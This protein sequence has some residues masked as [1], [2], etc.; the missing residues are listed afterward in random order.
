MAKPQQKNQRNVSEPL[1][2]PGALPPRVAAIRRKI[3]E[4]CAGRDIEALRIPV[5]WNEVRPLFERG[6]RRAPGADPIAILKELAADAEGLE[7][8]TLLRNV[9]RHACVRETT[10]GHTN[11]VWPAFAFHP[12]KAPSPDDRQAMLACVRFSDLRKSAAN[13]LPP[14]MRV[15]IGADGVWHYFWSH[16]GA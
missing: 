5:D 3:L 10:G 16:E 12:P 13:G 11:Y 2:D 7:N 1:T 8:L 6:A 4:A 15:G 14:P 9:L